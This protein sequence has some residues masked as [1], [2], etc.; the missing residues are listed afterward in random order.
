MKLRKLT[1]SAV[2]VDNTDGAATADGLTKKEEVTVKKNGVDVGVQ[3]ELDTKEVAT[4]TKE[5][6]S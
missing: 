1:R 4:A 5:Q 2:P 3:T 6:A